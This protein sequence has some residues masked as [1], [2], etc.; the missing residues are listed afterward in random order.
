MMRIYV[1]GN[2]TA[3]EIGRCLEVMTGAEV[4]TQLAWLAK[5]VDPTISGY[6]HVFTT[7][8]V[9]GPIEDHFPELKGKVTYY[10]RLI[11]TAFHPDCV[12]AN[13]SGR[14]VQ[15]PLGDYNSSI[16]LAG[17]KAGL[18]KD[19]ILNLFRHD[20]YQSLGF[21][22]HTND[23]WKNLVWE[24]APTSI[25]TRDLVEGWRS[26]PP[27]MHTINH[28][29]IGAIADL[30]RV[31]A[32]KA[33]L[34]V[35]FNSP[36]QHL[37][38][39][40]I[41]NAVWPIYPEIG[42]AFGVQ[43]SYD[44]KVAQGDGTW[45]RPK[46][47]P[48]EEFVEQSLISYQS[49]DPDSVECERL[50][51]PAYAD[52]RALSSQ[53]PP[54]RKSSH[55]YAGL[56]NR[57]FWNRSV[58]KIA[59]EEVD[60]VSPGMLTIAK[61]DKV[62]TA[63]SCFA[64][65]ISRA[66][67]RSG[68]TFYVPE[69]GDSDRNFGVYSCRYGNLYTAHQLLQLFDRAYGKFSPLENSW[70]RPDGRLAD[71]FRPEIEPNGFASEGALLAD[72]TEHLAHVR[73]MFESLDVFV[74]TLGLTEA[75]RSKKDG[76][77]YP[78][79]P[80]VSAGTFDPEQHEFINLTAGDVT[81]A[82]LAF[83]DRLRSVNSTAR[84]ILTVSPVPLAATYENRHVLTSTTYSKAALRV[85]AEAVTRA[86]DDVYYFPSYEII[87]GNFNRGSYY[88]D[89]LRNIKPAGVSHVMRL[90]LEHC[91]NQT[92]GIQSEL[93][94]LEAVICEEERLGSL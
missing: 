5:E 91:T 89:D 63:G 4:T 64:Q 57:Q 10:P 78:L 26:Q 71:P 28:P 21:F 56:P 88:E 81:D 87:T 25:G 47:I 70:M 37:V 53:K 90:F 14:P 30:S 23:H 80:G 66:L 8:C 36:E 75:W 83:V 9:D 51:N 40:L 59:A 20:V 55:P 92:S 13:V 17:W 68:F 44:F 38:D 31:M 49:L 72:Q 7:H 3:R 32:K 73:T 22:D 69:A 15:S 76:S 46:V 82:M 27:F 42:R 54:S 1:V 34:N 41:L 67:H 24:E 2:C 62:A 18:T 33:G 77:V 16:V 58:T 43:G 52:I 84:V 79:A 39:N 19:E 65:H 61:S 29:K 74:F 6:D 94:S 85:A 50:K 93:K 45:H 11:F 48:L 60:P 35:K 12:Y 86:R